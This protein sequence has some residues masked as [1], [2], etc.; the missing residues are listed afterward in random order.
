MK[1]CLEKLMAANRWRIRSGQMG[2]ENTEGWNGCFIVPVNGQLWQVMLSDHYGWRHLSATNT[3]RRQLPP[4][5]VMTRLKD[6][7][8]ADEETC[9]LYIPAKG[10]YIN[11]HPYVHHLWSSLEEPLLKPPVVLV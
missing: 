6:L 10:D 7:F 5:E 8:F 9:V 1:T 2:S 3:Q 11:E 4:W